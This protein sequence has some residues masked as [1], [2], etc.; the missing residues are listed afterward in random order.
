[1]QMNIVNRYGTTVLAAP[2]GTPHVGD[3]TR[4]DIDLNPISAN[5]ITQIGRVDIFF[6]A[7]YYGSGTVY[8]DDIGISNSHS[9]MCSGEPEGDVN[10]DCAVDMSDILELS[11]NWLRCTLVE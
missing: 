2:Y 9:F 5:E 6:T 3:W 4:W 10:Q 7:N 8:F 11:E 1:M